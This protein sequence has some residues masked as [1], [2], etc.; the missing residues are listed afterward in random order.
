MFTFVPLYCTPSRII[1]SR[2]VRWAKNAS[3]MSERGKH[4][5]FGWEG[6]NERERW[7]DQDGDR[8]I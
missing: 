4:A 3:R 5:R 2:R 8:I 1:K 7:E 6:Q